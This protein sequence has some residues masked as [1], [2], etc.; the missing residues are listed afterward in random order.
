MVSPNTVFSELVATTLNQHRKDVADNIS[1]GN[2]LLA[3]LM[4]KGRY[5]T[6]DGGQQ[7]VEPLDYTENSSYQR[8]SGY[9]RLNISPTSVLSAAQY[10]WKQCSVHITASGLELRQNAGKNQ[11]I[12]LAEARIANALRT[13]KNKLSEDVYSDGSADQGK[14]ISGLQAVVSDSGRGTVGGIN[15]EEFAFWRNKVQSAAAPMQGGNAVEVSKETIKQLMNPLYLDLCR[16]NNRPDLIVSSNDYFSFYW[17]SLQDLQ[18]Y[19]DDTG[20]TAGFQ[21]LKYV[22]ADVIHDGGSGIPDGHMYFL[23]TEYLKLVVHQ[24][25]NMT[26]M[27]EKSILDQDA[28]VIPLLWM[29]NLV[30]SNRALQGVLKS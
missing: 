18:R 14:Q 5:E 29:G 30:C 23:N 8:Y 13:F 26:Q 27:A 22:T 2:A 1:K 24:D 21:S 10:D 3:R 16:G 6:V 7:I 28:V 17:E 12:R 25:A 15:S 20:A 9:D 4:E 19:A 11:L